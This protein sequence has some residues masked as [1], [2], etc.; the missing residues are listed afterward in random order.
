MAELVTKGS[1]GKDLKEREENWISRHVRS[2]QYLLQIVKCDDIACCGPFLSAYR[3]IVPDRFLPPPYAVYQS[4][5]EG[6][7]WIRSDKTGVYL[8]LHQAMQLRS[9]I[10]PF[11][12]RKFPKQLP[13]DAFNPGVKEDSLKKRCCKICGLYSGTIKSINK[14]QKDCVASRRASRVS[15]G[16]GASNSNEVEEEEDA[17]I[18]RR[19]RP[20]RIAAVRQREALCVMQMQD[21]EWVSLDD[22]EDPELE[23]V[24]NFGDLESGTPLINDEAVIQ[25]D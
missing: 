6:L 8:S 24:P 14:H 22:I 11:I 3:T 5:E 18:P 15:G 4:P 19:V 17:L 1:S 20:M 12:H 25:E 21:M 23:G 10:P 9:L 16:S 7:K 2:S 13:Y